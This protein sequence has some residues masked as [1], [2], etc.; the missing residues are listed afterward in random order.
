MKFD[1]S[2]KVDLC[3]YGQ[4]NEQVNIFAGNIYFAVDGAYVGRVPFIHS[5]L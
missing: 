4:V 5:I 2:N 1:R 3:Y